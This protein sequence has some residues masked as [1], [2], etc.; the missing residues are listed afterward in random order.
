MG[1]R[2]PIWEET[3]K[4]AQALQKALSTA[5]MDTRVFV[6]MRYWHPFSDGAAL[7]VKNFTPDHIVALPL[8][9]QYSTTT[10]A[11]SF[12]DWDRAA[13]KLGFARPLTRV[14]CYPQEPGFIR[15]AAS[16]IQAAMGNLQPGLSYRLLLSAHGLP[17][18]IVADG[19]PYQWQVEQTARALRGCVED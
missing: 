13:K 18:K 19:D 5:D 14:C 15:A 11:S 10:T 12:K 7:A 3:Q 6:A 4:Q 16:R 8:Y 1:G 9:P 17:K 2:S